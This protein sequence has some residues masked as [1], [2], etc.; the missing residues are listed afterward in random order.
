MNFEFTKPLSEMTKQDK[1]LVVLAYE[2][3]K[4]RYGKKF[5]ENL[6][7]KLN[8][9][10][11]TMI[12]MGVS[13]YFLNCRMNARIASGFGHMP[14]ERQTY[15][16]AHLYDEEFSTAEK[17]MD[18]I[19]TD[20]SAP[21]MTYGLGRGSA[22]GSIVTY[23]LG[24]TAVEPTQYNLLFERFLNPERVSMPDIDADF[25]KSEFDYGCRD[26][27]LAC[28]AK[29]YGN[30]GVCGIT[31]P[32]TLAARAA[33][34]AMGRVLSEKK[35]GSTT[36]YLKIVDRINACVPNTP[37]VKLSDC[38]SDIKETFAPKEKEG[39]TKEETDKEKR[40]E[41]IA[42]KIVD[43]ALKSENLN[44]NFG[45][46][47]CG[48]IVV[49]NRDVGASAPLMWDSEARQWKIEMDAETAESRGFLKMDYLGLKTLNII[50]AVVRKVYET[51]HIY[52]NTEKIPE[53]QKVLKEIFWKGFTNAVFQFESE[54]MKKML[55]RFQPSS[56]EDLILLVACYRPGPMQYLD[57]IIAIKHGE[58]AEE[59]AVTRISEYVPAFNK[60]VSPTYMA[61][62]Y[63][64]QI[65]QV[66]RMVGYTMGGADN[67]R[68][69][70]GHKK[71]D[72]LVAE[73][74]NFI[75]GNEEKHIA[76]AIKTG[77]KEED[78]K[79]LF[80]E[81]IEFAK[82]SFNKSHAACYAITAYI[83]GY[84]K[85][86]YPT[87]FYAMT[88]NY[89]NQDKYAPLISEARKLKV[90]VN[91]PDINESETDFTGKDGAVYFGFSGIKNLESAAGRA[92]IDGGGN[93][94]SLADFVKRVNITKSNAELL[95]KAGAFDCLYKNRAAVLNV[96]PA[97]MDAKDDMK[98][99]TKANDTLEQEI[100]DIKSG[101]KEEEL[102]KKYKI[103]T[104]SLP[105]VTKLT[106]KTEANNA[107]ISDD[108]E[109][110]DS[111][112]VPEN[113]IERD[114]DG[115]LRDEKELLGLY[116][117]RS[118]LDDY[119][120]DRNS[121]EI[122]TLDQYRRATVT[123]IIQDLRVVKRKSDGKP[124]AFFNLADNGGQVPCCLFTSEYE[125]Y[126]TYAKDGAV[127]TIVGNVEEDKGKMDED[128]NPVIQ[129]FVKKMES[130]RK[131][132]TQY[133]LFLKNGLIDW[134][135]IY[136]ELK[137]YRSENG[138]R[139]MVWSGVSDRN[140]ICEF[141]VREEAKKVFK[142]RDL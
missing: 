17:V 39:K 41:E 87:E 13:S 71:M 113:H 107:A 52:I 115:E 134:M 130:P 1:E 76:G 80:E 59:N 112:A 23:S 84:L 123:G 48:N 22:A 4:K 124:L 26:I 79:D 54:G 70:M 6:F 28:T 90:K 89:V 72:I 100:E 126:E 9:E 44:V 14:A 65:M 49:G 101:M 77:I 73:K 34:K 129:M 81:M 42:M 86:Y 116:V 61:L 135:N 141:P 30:D 31:T 40:E 60:I 78:A 25:S 98:A 68:R 43:L 121:V 75:Y 62:V 109:Y 139:L 33:V 95:V 11:N 122:S 104:K 140:F 93:Y 47:A 132:K 38:L 97:Y 110:L 96:L 127:V 102:R 99:K 8:F 16:R 46:H 18:Y 66:F 3:C 5:D 64:E 2:G 20:Q 125:K 67:V 138:H 83:T 29:M 69:A 92:V 128:G 94:K 35:T 37:G 27:V 50:T 111:L 119:E 56:I 118:P 45:R 108:I 24:I 105:T 74:Q 117:S 63:Q 88:L 36:A 21:G 120:A 137:K 114:M 58:Q 10:L 131:K 51:R 15:L 53:D 85:Y 103:T 91:A 133:L 7:K 32:A 12:N 136:P 82:Y 106:E 57:G 19:Y 55:M 142:M